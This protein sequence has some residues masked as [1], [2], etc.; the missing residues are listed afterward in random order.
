MVM[1]EISHKCKVNRRAKRLQRRGLKWT[2]RLHQFHIGW[3]CQN[4]QTKS[5]NNKCS[6][7]L[8]QIK[9]FR[10]IWFF[11][12]CASFVIS[13][14]KKISSRSVNRFQY[15]ALFWIR[16]IQQI[17]VELRNCCAFC[18]CFGILLK[19]TKLN[20]WSCTWI[21]QLQRLA[22]I[23]WFYFIFSLSCSLSFSLTFNLLLTI[24]GPHQIIYEIISCPAIWIQRARIIK[25]S[26]HILMRDHCDI[27]IL[28]LV[29][30]N[31]S[32]PKRLSAL[33]DDTLYHLDVKECMFFSGNVEP[34]ISHEIINEL[35]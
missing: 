20:E 14:P 1:D 9:A 4:I 5:I 18:T 24:H 30:A 15:F 8:F 11:N 31:K 25:N 6:N 23:Q 26:H 12:V 3:R 17:V 7:G 34:C 29:A 21:I 33:I 10:L 35:N 13:G 27:S 32:I 22:L 28:W 19:L 2:F 16:K